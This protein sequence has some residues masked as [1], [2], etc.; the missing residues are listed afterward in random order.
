MTLHSLYSVHLFLKIFPQI[1]AAETPELKILVRS[2][3]TVNFWIWEVRSWARTIPTLRSPSHRR[4]LLQQKA[5][6]NLRSHLYGKG[7]ALTLWGTLRMMKETAVKEESILF[8]KHHAFFQLE[9]FFF[10]FAE[11]Q[12]LLD[13]PNYLDLK[14]ML[15]T[16]W[17]PCLFNRWSHRFTFSKKVLNK[18]KPEIIECQINSCTLGTTDDQWKDKVYQEVKL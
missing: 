4:P 13:Y 2:Q 10:F 7:N 14:T 6:R 5:E 16:N 9:Y 3:A 17:A 12:I 1:L 15:L 11:Y 8:K 18:L